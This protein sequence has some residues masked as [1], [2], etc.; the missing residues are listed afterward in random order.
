MQVIRL[1]GQRKY[2]PA[3]LL[4]FLENEGLASLP[5]LAHSYGF[6]AARTPNEMRDNQMN[7]V[8]IPLVL[9]CLFHG[10]SLPQ[11]R[12]PCKG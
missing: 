1:D 10:S 3:L 11:F 6:A 4:A 2:L 9:K 5:K 12:L 8:F 7:M